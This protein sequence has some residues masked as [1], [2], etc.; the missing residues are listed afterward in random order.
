MM[1]L[2]NALPQNTDV[3]A[4]TWASLNREIGKRVPDV[5]YI[6]CQLNLV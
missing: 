1:R 4:L 3:V 5:A 2:G 6:F